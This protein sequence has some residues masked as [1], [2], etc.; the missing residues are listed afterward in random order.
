[1]RLLLKA[2]AGLLMVAVVCAGYVIW[3]LGTAWRIRD[4]IRNNDAEYLADKVEW[5]SVKR[6]L[7]PSMLQIAL[8]P[9]AGQ[10][11]AAEA[12]AGATPKTGLIRKFKAY[13]GEKAVD[14]MIDE[15]VTPEGLPK[16]FQYGKTYREKIKG[17][18][19]KDLP[20]AEKAKRSWSR[21]VRAE[22][23]S[24]TQFELEMR[25]RGTSG[26]TYAGTFELKGLEWKLTGLTVQQPATGT[27]AA[28]PVTAVE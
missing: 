5:S 12:D 7:K 16:L 8:A 18:D 2:L 23:K 25:D 4:A 28:S 6:T 9:G 13:L 3:P 21:V 27:A 1:M 19:E 26:R 10:P 20:F 15:Y 24:F 11:A 22:F 14:K 17:D